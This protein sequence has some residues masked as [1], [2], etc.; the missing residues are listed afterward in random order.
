MTKLLEER[1]GTWLESLLG[2]QNSELVD[3]LKQVCWQ[4]PGM[5]DHRIDQPLSTDGAVV[6]ADF[7]RA[8]QLILQKLLGQQQPKTFPKAVVPERIFMLDIGRKHF[9]LAALERLLD[10]LALFQFNYL[11]LHFSENSGFRIAS[12]TCP[13]MVSKEHL[14]QTEIR[15]LITYGDARGIGFIPDFDTPGHVGRLLEIYPEWALK[16]ATGQALPAALDITNPE[17][18]RFLQKIYQEYIELFAESRYFHIGGDEFV[19]F[20]EME[21]IPAL[22]KMAKKIYGATG[23][24]SD[25]YINYVNQMATL[26]G[27]AGMIPRV[28]SDGFYRENQRGN[29]PLSQQVEISYWTRWQ[30]QMAPV[31]RYLEEGYTLINHNDN[32]LYY[33]LGEAANYTYPTY[34]K[35]KAEWQPELFS[36]GQVVSSA[37]LTSSV[38]GVALCVW[39]DLP[40]SK[41]ETDVLADCFYLMAAV[42]EKTF[43]IDLGDQQTF[44]QLYQQIQ[45]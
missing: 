10:Y 16:D 7:Q 5:N 20:E 9:S 19:D 11:Q 33:V 2:E 21:Q 24:A 22:R 12:T 17:A 1:I 40:D 44:Q 38:K 45:K 23:Q 41:R 34:E 36:Q 26:I 37:E 39:S 15:Q 42:M 14:S 8:T 35:I 6:E 3:E 27:E 4:F 13:E 43:G 30:P 29:Q 32:Y 31:S 25:V 28:W 18:V